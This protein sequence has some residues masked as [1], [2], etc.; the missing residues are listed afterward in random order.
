MTIANKYESGLGATLPNLTGKVDGFSKRCL[1]LLVNKRFSLVSEFSR[2]QFD[3]PCIVPKSAKG[4][5]IDM[6]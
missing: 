6:R 3:D 4:Y 5:S 2:V 1:F